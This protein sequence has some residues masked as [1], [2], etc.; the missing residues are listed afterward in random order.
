MGLHTSL[1]L[2]KRTVSWRGEQGA[3]GSWKRGFLD[4]FRHPF[5]DYEKSPAN[6]PGFVSRLVKTGY[7]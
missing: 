5:V 4:I 1:A 3:L 7:L 6:W 2:Q